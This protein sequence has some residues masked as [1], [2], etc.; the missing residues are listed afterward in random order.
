MKNTWSKEKAWEWYDSRPWLR[1]CNYLQSDCVNFT[2]QWQEMDCEEK[3]ETADR[4]LK[5]AAETGMN[6]VRIFVDFL[7]WSQQHDGFMERFDRF[8]SIAWKHGISCMVCL[9]NDCLPPVDSRFSTPHLGPQRCD[10]GYHGGMSTSIFQ[11]E[12]TAE[13][14]KI[15]HSY[16]DVPETEAK[17]YEMVREIIE[18]YRDDERVLVWDLFNEAGNNNRQDITIPHVKRIFEIADGIRPSQPVTACAWRGYEYDRLTEVEQ[19]VLNNSDIITYH[20]YASYE[21]N[22]C[23]IKEY[24]RFG[25]PLMNTE[26]MAR[27]LGSSVQELFPLFYLEKIGCYN[28]GFVAGKMQTFEPWMGLWEDYRKNPDLPYD[29]TKWFH[30]L[31]RPSLNPYDPKEIIILKK[32]AEKAEQD[33][34]RGEHHGRR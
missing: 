31:Y 2:E 18:K 12:F 15:G 33:F 1:G 22:I 19:F 30:D 34:V 29:F 8:L 3:L 7:V 24:Q 17:Y 10:I 4:E 32:Y 13:G 27:V 26:W 23:A 11:H 25:R 9:A 5:L 21:E 6:T 20:Q 14:G 16:L 28:W